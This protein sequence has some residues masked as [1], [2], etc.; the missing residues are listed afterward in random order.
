MGFPGGASGEE[1]ACQCRRHKRYG[2]DPWVGK[3][4]WGRAWQPTLVFFHGQ[5]SL[6]GYGPWGS[7]AKNTGVGCHALLQGIFLTQGSNPYLLCLLPWP[8][9]SLA[10]AVKNPPA[11]AGNMRDTAWVRKIPWRRAWQPSPVFLPGKSRGQ[12]SLVGYNLWGHRVRHVST[13]TKAM[14][15]WTND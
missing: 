3:I 10:L 6:A 2:F 14:S 12:R 15:L 8:V 13:S 1:P 4:P 7:L 9:G 5:R 11:N